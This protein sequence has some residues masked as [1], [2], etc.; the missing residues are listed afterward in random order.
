MTCNDETMTDTFGRTFGMPSLSKSSLPGIVLAGWL[1]V[2]GAA[3]AQPQFNLVIGY[4]PGAIY[5]AYGRL[6]ARH[7]GR[8]L[9]GN[10]TGVVQNMPGAGSLRAA[11]YLYVVAPK[12]GSAIRLFPRD[13]AMQ[14]LP[15]P[16]RL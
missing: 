12:D 14:P 2:P 16:Q 15:D 7:L 13:I 9:P 11:N 4:S 10:P 8:H 6:V 1:L 5:D 3:S